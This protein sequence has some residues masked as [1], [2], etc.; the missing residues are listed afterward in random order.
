MTDAAA[1]VVERTISCPSAAEALNL[2]GVWYMEERWIEAT[3]G[4]KEGSIWGRPAEESFVTQLG[5]V[6][7]A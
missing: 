6:I 7:L 4:R 3:E 2:D 1:A 5:F